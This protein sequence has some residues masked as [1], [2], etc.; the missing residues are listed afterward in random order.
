M[1][2]GKETLP[3]RIPETTVLLDEQIRTKVD[4][5]MSTFD[6]MADIFK[7]RQ[8]STLQA[9]IY[10]DRDSNQGSAA[11]TGGNIERKTPITLVEAI[12]NDNGKAF[13]TVVSMF[14][15]AM[16]RPTPFM[17]PT[18]LIGAGASTASYPSAD[19][20]VVVR[21]FLDQ[22]GCTSSII[23]PAE[24]TA[25]VTKRLKEAQT[26]QLRETREQTSEVT[27]SPVRF[28]IAAAGC[29][30][31]VDGQV[32]R[33]WETQCWKTD[34]PQLMN[35]MVSNNATGIRIVR[36]RTMFDD[37][38]NR[39]RAKFESCFVLKPNQPYSFAFQSAGT[40]PSEYTDHVRGG[41]A[42][43]QEAQQ[44]YKDDMKQNPA[45]EMQWG[46]GDFEFKIIY[47][48]GAEAPLTVFRKV[49]GTWREESLA[50]ETSM[51]AINSGGQRFKQITV[52]PMGNKLVFFFG[53]W[54]SGRM[55][56]E[57][58]AYIQFSKDI[59]IPESKITAHLYGGKGAFSFFPITHEDSGILVSPTMSPGYRPNVAWPILSYFGRTKVGRDDPI[60]P[61]IDTSIK[62]ISFPQPE[63]QN[64]QSDIGRVTTKHLSGEIRIQYQM[65]TKELSE[66]PG[67]S[68][69]DLLSNKINETDQRVAARTFPTVDIGGSGGDNIL[70]RWAIRL[71]NLNGA[72]EQRI[73]SPIVD[74]IQMNFVPPDKLVPLSPNPQIDFNDIKV[75][76]INEA[77]QQISASVVLDNRQNPGVDTAAEEGGGGSAIG[78]Y[79]MPISRDDRGRNFIGIKPI[80]IRVGIKDDFKRTTSD[81]DEQQF[82]LNGYTIG[83]ARRITNSARTYK[84]FGEAPVPPAFG[85]EQ[86]IHFRGFIVSRDYGRPHSAKSECT[87]TCE[88]V[89]RRAKDH[90]TANLPIFDGWCLAGNTKVLTPDGLIDIDQLPTDTVFDVLSSY[91]DSTP[92][93]VR[94]CIAVKRGQ[95]QLYKITLQN[96]Q[97][98]RATEDHLFLLR[99]NN[100]PRYSSSHYAA[101]WVKLSDLNEGDEIKVSTNS[102]KRT[103]LVDDQQDY[104]FDEMLGWMLGDGWFTENDRPSCGIL[105]APD[106][107]E[108]RIKLKPVFDQW[109]ID[110]LGYTNKEHTDV[111]GVRT[112]HVQHRDILTALKALGHKP[113]K[114]TSKELPDYIWT[115]SIQKQCAFL[116]G[117]FSAD[118]YVDSSHGKRLSI[119]LTSNS[120]RLVEQ[121]QILLTSMG[122]V[123]NINHMK[124][125]GQLNGKDRND[126]YG[127]ELNGESVIGFMRHIGFNLKKK[128]GQWEQPQTPA[129]PKDFRR[130]V[131]VEM[132]TVEE[133]YDISMPSVHAFYANGVYTHNC[134]LAVMYYLL[135]D[136]G[137]QDDEILMFQDRLDPTK[138]VTLRKVLEDAGSDPDTF[139]GGCFDGHVDG[140]PNAVPALNN[141]PGGISIKVPGPII[142]A[143]MPLAGFSDNPNYMFQMGQNTWECCQSTREFTGFYLY[144]NAFG[145]MIYQPAE[146]ALLINSPSAASPQADHTSA[147]AITGGGPSRVR[148][149]FFEISR[150]MK[151]GEIEATAY[152]QYQRKLNAVM[153]TQ[154][155]RNALAIVGL[156]PIEERNGVITD[157]A[158]HI[159]TKKLAEGN[160]EEAIDSQAF[161]PWLKWAI[162]KNP[163]W[164]NAKYNQYLSEQYFARLTRPLVDVSFSAWGQE[165]LFAYEVIELDESIMNETG[166]DQCLIVVTS[167]TH[168]LDAAARTW[169][170][171]IQGELIETDTFDFS[172]HVWGY[173][174]RTQSPGPR[175]V[176]TPTGRK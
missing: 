161:A 135:R 153:N 60:E 24:V 134:N 117:L 21:K 126:E 122:M 143:T 70:T 42:F 2:V 19:D 54:G 139:S 171:D 76:T 34:D 149:K 41:G 105:F 56:E 1:A 136:A 23:P 49:E 81:R 118:G 77:V 32:L 14:G 37:I 44:F 39:L 88:D 87:L 91:D 40:M 20:G 148:F 140:F 155:S 144:P 108:A 28:Q 94:N 22:G 145:N 165:G 157:W 92:V 125:N 173:M 131:S 61:G 31:L 124:K 119:M 47:R 64:L 164:N 112:I 72:V 27:S 6:R 75:V 93:V 175:A 168:Q 169:Y 115:A 174:S 111:N 103:H 129:K 104:A 65:Y 43:P 13:A 130:V 78:K 48:A 55:L 9:S 98:I 67:R 16:L 156:L 142:H 4:Q 137:Y 30:S 50:N 106:D 58:S 133:T 3:R 138:Q 62:T 38:P 162:I 85:Q 5:S 160:I 45:L 36:N 7:S 152:S 69:I 158:A 141:L 101:K 33:T 110:H 100:K 123:S 79:T 114:A 99:D 159:T 172:P 128:N 25:E 68:F 59:V 163:H 8:K 151:S 116:R 147:E 46:G 146:V 15:R 102:I 113:G 127:L 73:Y 11:E 97:S 166:I 18:Y 26:Q 66:D 83:D 90:L 154:E 74:W 29:G 107:E 96:G 51:N 109:L 150:R 63:S 10:T 52:Y 35:E 132:D 71:E 167:I 84:G 176:T 120:K 121:T 53:Y 12:R 57:L 82:A 95:K 89:S 17:Q 80:T 170:S 86:P